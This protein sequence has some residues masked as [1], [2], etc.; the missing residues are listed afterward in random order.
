MKKT[1]ADQFIDA[2]DGDYFYL[3][4]GNEGIY[5]LGQLT[6]P[7]NV[8]SQKGEGWLDRPFRIIKTSRIREPYDGKKKWW[9]PNENSTFVP[10]PSEEISLLEKQILRPYF[11]IRLEDFG[12]RK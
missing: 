9:T 7:A 10:I 11:G 1:Q 4:N 6:G 8:F 5:L 2:N 3:T 12:L